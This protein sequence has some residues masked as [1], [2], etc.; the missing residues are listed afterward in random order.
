M[1]S[2]TDIISTYFQCNFKQKK[3]ETIKKQQK[4]RIKFV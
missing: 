2:N 4:T 1:N 3:S